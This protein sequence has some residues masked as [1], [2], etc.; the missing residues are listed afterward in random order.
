M[1]RRYFLKLLGTTALGAIALH[2]WPIALQAKPAPFPVY[3]TFD[4]GPTTDFPIRVEIAGPT[5]DALDVLKAEQVQATFFLHGRSINDWEGMVIARMVNEG[6]AVGNH[7]WQHGGVTTK[8][9]PMVTEMAMLYLRTELRIREML[10]GADED[11]YNKYVT[12]PK[13]FRRPGGGNHLVNFLDPANFGRLQ[14]SPYLKEYKEQLNWLKGVYDY[15]GWHINGGDGIVDKA[16]RPDTVAEM[17]AWIVKGGYGYRGV[18]AYLCAEGKGAAQS[19]PRR[20]VE[21]TAGLI[22]L[23][24]DADRVT[25]DALPQ[26]IRELRERGA[27]FRALPRP[28]DIPNARTVGIGY[29][30]TPD[31]SGALCEMG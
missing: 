16:I 22:I 3:L 2:Q 14:G 31:P 13:L 5:I 20:A 9:D 10:Q 26:I 28:Q 1:H 29:A 23:L 8:F 21:A 18:D 27:E 17:T 6:H 15:S 7:L 19:A 12:Q 11:A 25:V 24:H 30:P 4:D